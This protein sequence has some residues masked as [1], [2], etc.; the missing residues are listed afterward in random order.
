MTADEAL[1]SVDGSLCVA[2]VA[3]E[4]ENGSIGHSRQDR[5]WCPR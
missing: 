1:E 3:E 2:R 4:N 5:A